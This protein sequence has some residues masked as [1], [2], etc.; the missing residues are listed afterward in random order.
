MKLNYKRGLKF[1]TL[2]LSALLIAT[3]SATIYNYMYMY[4]TPIG[5]KGIYD[6]NFYAGADFNDA[7]GSIT[8]NLQ[9]VTF[10]NM[11]GSNGSLATYT[12]PVRI[13]N[14]G[15]TTYSVEL[16]FDSWTFQGNAQTTL[17]YVNVTLYDSGDSFVGRMSLIP[18]GGGNSTTGAHN[19]AGSDDWWHVQWDILWFA[20]ATASDSVNIS[21]EI[22]VHD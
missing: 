12:D 19:L 9:T 8:N 6:V 4:A 20:N 22:I 21:L 13:C 10:T 11:K 15:S 17:S 3:A 18:A 1:V 16:T 2:L 14:N 5:V 7:G